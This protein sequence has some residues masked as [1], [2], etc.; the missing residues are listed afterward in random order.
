MLSSNIIDQPDNLNYVARRQ[1][2]GQI[3]KNIINVI[4]TIVL[5]IANVGTHKAKKDCAHS[6]SNSI[7]SSRQ[8]HINHINLSKFINEWGDEVVTS[9]SEYR[10]ARKKPMLI[11]RYTYGY[12]PIKLRIRIEF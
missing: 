7:R 4:E 6:K 3:F 10:S 9:S 2:P 12:L 5:S 8:I 11:S 1:Y